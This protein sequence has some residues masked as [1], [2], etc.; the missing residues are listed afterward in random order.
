MTLSAHSTPKR[1]RGEGETTALSPLKF[2]FEASLATDSEDG[3]NSP[4]S[5]VAHRFRG[6]ELHESDV[7]GGSGGGVASTFSSYAHDDDEPDQISKRQRHDEHM[8]DAEEPPRVVSD[9]IGT[10]AGDAVG[11]TDQAGKTVPQPAPVSDEHLDKNPPQDSGT[12]P[13]P[14]P[15]LPGPKVL[16]K[17]RAGTPPLRI[18][19]LLS[20]LGDTNKDVVDPVRA[21]L[22]WHEDEITIYDPDDEDDDGTGING[23]GFKPTAAIAHARVMKRRQQMAEYRRREESDAR[24]RRNQRRRGAAPIH[25]TSGESSSS[26]PGSQGD[27]AAQP[28][29]DGSPRKVRFREVE[30]PHVAITSS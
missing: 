7:A 8:P 10:Q 18:K 9:L 4:R 16:G 13:A 28:E 2:S 1:K 24:A 20:K 29:G 6:L 22:T 5:R 12:T 19:K 3:S 15:D 17:K 23:V 26:P 14:M 30:A 11:V 21:A 25:R 27:G